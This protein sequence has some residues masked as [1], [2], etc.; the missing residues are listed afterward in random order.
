MPTFSH[1]SIPTP[2]WLL[3][4]VPQ[5][6]GSQEPPV[7]EVSSTLFVPRLP[8]ASPLLL[9][10]SSSST[11]FNFAFTFMTMASLVS[12]LPNVL[13]TIFTLVRKGQSKNEDLSSSHTGTPKTCNISAQWLWLGQYTPN[14]SRFVFNPGGLISAHKNAGKR[15]PKT[16]DPLITMSDATFPSL[17]LADDLAVFSAETPRF[18]SRSSLTGDSQDLNPPGGVRPA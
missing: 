14:A 16:R 8:H 12:T 17:I 11:H 1:L 18:F 9:L 10:S 7:H 5:L 2:Q 3:Y 4:L 13:A 6:L 15:K